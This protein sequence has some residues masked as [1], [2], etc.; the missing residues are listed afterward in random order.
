MR[1]VCGIRKLSELPGEVTGLT[2][3]EG[4]LII[5]FKDHPPMLAPE[6]SPGHF[7][8]LPILGSEPPDCRSLPLQLPR[9]I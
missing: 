7:E 6:T 9:W 4:M 3:Y 1:R 5:A 2:M 8:L